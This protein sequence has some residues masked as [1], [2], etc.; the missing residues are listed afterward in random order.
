MYVNP[1]QQYLGVYLILARQARCDFTIGTFQVAPL[2]RQMAHPAGPALA[3]EPMGI[4]VSMC[5][6]T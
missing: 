3:L 4:I 5:S 2:C 1:D 6:K